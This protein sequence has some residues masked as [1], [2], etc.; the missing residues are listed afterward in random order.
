MVVKTIR[1]DAGMG[2]D[3]DVT[4]L[5]VIHLVR[6]PRAVIHSQIKTFN[7]AHKYRKYFNGPSQQDEAASTNGTQVRVCALMLSLP[8]SL[9]VQGTIRVMYLPW[10]SFEGVAAMPAPKHHSS[11]HTRRI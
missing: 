4:G 10:P 3:G 1:A 8:H 11:A 7:V 2:D 6:D 9:S 5:L